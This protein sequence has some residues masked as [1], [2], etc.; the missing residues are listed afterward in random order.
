M[1]AAVLGGAEV[2]DEELETI[3]SGVESLL[4]SRPLTTVS[5]DS[6]DEPV[7]TPNHFLIGQMGG[8]FLYQR[9]LTAHL[10]TQGSVGEECRSLRDM[11]GN[12]GCECICRILDQDQSGSFLQITFRLGMWL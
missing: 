7:L 12:G 10:L 9:V 6:N 11:F 8:D 4:N 3:F 5:D 2:I 1:I